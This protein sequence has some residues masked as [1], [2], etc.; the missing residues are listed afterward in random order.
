MGKELLNVLSGILLMAVGAAW[1]LVK[2]PVLGDIL[3]GGDLVPFW[4]SLLV[5]FAA[6][7]GGLLVLTGTIL[8]W[9]GIDDYKNK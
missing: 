9:M 5:V 1:Y 2:V 3:E 8:A 6:C 7:F 4:R